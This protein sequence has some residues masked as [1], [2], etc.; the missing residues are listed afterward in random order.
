ML[1]KCADTVLSVDKSADAE[2]YGEKFLDPPDFVF[3]LK[4]LSL[5]WK[6]KAYAGGYGQKL[7]GWFSYAN[8]MQVYAVG[9]GWLNVSDGFLVRISTFIV[10]SLL[11]FFYG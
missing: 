5:F 2:G 3:E 6:S 8:I 4:L 10:Q 7:C 9:Y 1:W 11:L